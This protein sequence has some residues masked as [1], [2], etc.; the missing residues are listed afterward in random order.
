[1]TAS[2]PQCGTEYLLPK[3]SLDEKLEC[4]ECHRVF[5]PKTTAGK[6]VRKPDHSK[7]YVMFGVG[8]VVLVGLFFMMS[9][10][11][12]PVAKAKTTTAP[13]EAPVTRYTHPRASQIAKWAQAMGGS[14]QLIV[15][16]HNDMDALAKTLEVTPG[17]DSAIF[18]A[19]ATHPSTRFLRELDA[20]SASLATDEAMTAPTG[21][22][23][24]YVTPKQ[25][26]DDWKRNTRGE[27]E[28]SFR[29]DGEQ[30][31]VTGWR[32]TMEPVRNPA[33]PDDSAR[34]F[35]P[36]ADIAKPQVVEFT[37]S[38]GVTRKRTESE[39]AAVP[40]WSDATPAQ[41]EKADK[42]VADILASAEP[43]APGGLFG[44]ATLSV[45]SMEDRKAV[46]P[47]VL[48]AM[49]ELYGDV[50]ANNLKLSQLDRAL[51]TFV[52]THV[53]YPAASTGDPEKDKQKRESCVRQW[54]ALWWRYSSGNLGEFYDMRENL[55]EPLEDDKK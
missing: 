45:R 23:M 29:M 13:K 55:D 25:G 32:V 44:R 26:T 16:T 31:K 15:K 19:I 27:I 36:N 18:A 33:K 14:N 7:V 39:P 4:S 6:R 34:S 53:A 30:V 54:F 47:R 46:V 49:Y 5:F 51:Q 1:V 22:A 37:D 48:N 20:D 42:I 9:S 35:V 28:V 38:T 40:H 11:S 10:G 3:D 8:A 41:R 50:N 17:D 12:E 24:V 52:G 43:D 21:K 2:C